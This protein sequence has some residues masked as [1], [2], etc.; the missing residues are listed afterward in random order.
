MPQR[1]QPEDQQLVQDL[2]NVTNRTCRACQK[3]LRNK[4]GL[5]QHKKHCPVILSTRFRRQFAAALQQDN[6]RPPEE[7]DNGGAMDIDNG[8][9]PGGGGDEA[10]GD[11]AGKVWREHHEG[12]T[13]ALQMLFGIRGF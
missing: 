12:L 5:T 9:G 11:G 3:I 4:S 7:E 13:G 6:D 10:E 1:G 8:P 2:Q